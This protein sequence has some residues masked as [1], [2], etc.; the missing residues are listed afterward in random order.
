MLL[1]F[2]TTQIPN[3]RFMGFVSYKKPWMHFERTSNEFVLYLIKNGSLY[4]EEDGKQYHLKK[5][6]CI[7]LE[8]GKR[9]IGYEASPCDYYYIHFKDASLRPTDQDASPTFFSKMLIKRNAEIASNCLEYDELDHPLSY[10]P[11]VIDLQDSSVYYYML[12]KAIKDYNT[13]YEHYR[14]LV[15]SKLLE[16]FIR[17]SRDYVSSLYAKAGTTIQKKYI[18]ARSLLCYLSREY[19]NKITREDIEEELEISYDYLN[20]IFKEF[21]GDSIHQHLMKIRMNKAMELIETTQLKFSDIAYLVGVDDSF[22]FSKLFKKHTGMTP[23]DY[24]KSTAHH[25]EATQGK[26]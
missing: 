5:G 14:E 15:G 22:Y 20:R 26:G 10:I 24:L 17:L 4:I 3:V 19:C 1:Q 7:L 18:K 23:T 12:H 11:K 9:H 21:T 8:P 2:D 16:F 25:G 6:S 13:R